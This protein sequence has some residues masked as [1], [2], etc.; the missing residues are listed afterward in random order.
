MNGRYRG[1]LRSGVLLLGTLGCC[2]LTTS[3]S[4]AGFEHSYKS[5]Q[6][7]FETEYFTDSSSCARCHDNIVDD[8]G[9][10]IS[11]VKTWD[12]TMMR[13][14]FFDPFWRAKVQSEL[15]RLPEYSGII[16]EKCIRCHAPMASEQIRND[17]NSFHLFGTGGL[18]DPEN[19]YYP[20]AMDG[21]S[22]TLCHQILEEEKDSGDYS[23]SE[24]RVAFGPFEPDYSAMMDTAGGYY[25]TYSEH[26]SS[27]QFCA[28]CHDLYT[29]Y[30][31]EN[32]DIATGTFPEQTPYQEWRA[33]SY[34]VEGESFQ[35]CRDCHMDRSSTARVSA[36]PANTRERENVYGH[37]FLTENTMMLEMIASI[38]EDQGLEFNGLEQA[39]LDGKDYLAEAGEIEI[40]D[41]QW[42][43]YDQNNKVD[44]L[45]VE[46]VVTN[47][48]GHK[49]P[50]GIPVRRVFVHF[51]VYDDHGDLYFSSGDVQDDGSIY[52]VNA[53]YDPATFE[54]H[55]EVID[56][57]DDVQIYEGIMGRWETGKD[58]E[59]VSKVTYTLLRASHFKKDN[60]LLPK[61]A[62]SATIPELIKPYGQAVSDENFGN[63]QDTVTYIVP[64]LG[65]IR[66]A[67]FRIEAELKDQTLSYQMVHDLKGLIEE[68]QTGIIQTF[69]DEY[70]HHKVQYELIDRDEVYLIND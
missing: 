4:S 57:M 55:H 24:T 13:F 50:T 52:G 7:T 12:T 36:L 59:P 49:M 29:P 1:L 21:I 9:V 54:E 2:L 3:P 28:V 53:D 31:L 6:V 43:A 8:E 41:L 35:Q 15:L 10:D 20:M 26:I 51:T 34:A 67:S 38:A 58:S 39:V 66:S 14:S 56:S 5:G 48:T 65:K 32:G 60:R 40:R 47:K 63:G 45:Q 46:V 11:F 42:I 62:F 25:P 19:V 70:E 44:D 17:G 37:T 16:E 30:V 27:S 33:S 64:D 69:F 23:I 22:C 18:T 68:D 61:G